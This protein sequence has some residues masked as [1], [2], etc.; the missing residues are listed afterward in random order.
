MFKLFKY[1]KSYII[2]IFITFILVA[3][4]VMVDLSLP[5]YMSKI[6][7]TGIVSN[8]LDYIFKIGLKMLVISLM[9]ALCTIFIS[10]L[11]S[12]I[13]SGFAKTI[14]KEVFSKVEDFSLL[15][16]E[17]FGVSSLITRTTND[18]SQIQLF[19]FMLL[20]VVVAAP[21]MA[22]GGYIKAIEKSSSMAWVIGFSIFSLLIGVIILIII[23]LPKV[24]LLQKYIDKLNL[25]IRE[26]LIG[27]KD[28]KAF[29]NEEY[30]ENKFDTA[31]IDL[32][33]LNLYLNRIMS[34]VNPVIILILNMTVIM[35]I[36]FGAKQIEVGF[37]QVGNLMAFIQYV[38]QIIM[39]F[40]MLS[41]V[42][43]ILP[44]ATVSMQRVAEVINTNP[45]ITDQN[46]PVS[47]NKSRPGL[48]EFKNVSYKYPGAKE[49]VLNNISFKAKPNKVTAFVGSTG[50][51][52]STLINLLLRF[53]D[54]TEGKILIGNT[55]IRCLSQG[56]LRD[57]IGYV[58]QE[59]ILFSG[60]VESNL[61]YGKSNADNDELYE[62]AVR[63]ES[64][65][66]IKKRKRG[67]KSIV[68]QGGTNFSG[69]ER[70]RLSIARAL[71]KSPNIYIFD[72]SF[73]ALDFK[74]D[75]KIRSSFKNNLK[76]STILIIA[77]RINTIMDADQII[78]LDKGEIVGK[79]I[80]QDLLENCPVYKEIALSQ[81]SAEELL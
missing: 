15:E 80:H 35:I 38:M 4:Q 43:S 24:K 12:K 54:V 77:Q 30:Q 76:D 63:S 52:K 62:S 61:K 2:L 68:T 39:S 28:I 16:I 18:I 66:F 3:I 60:T 69:G 58:P 6:V 51:G 8:D 40:L 13:S 20:R 36:W 53:Y 21:I 27:L 5:D 74:T 26:H 33:N 17:K 19:I 50:S 79:G 71:I 57:N 32:S 49:N 10:F 55:D 44:R 46:N 23:G 65:D 14:R 31:N 45:A 75:K 41:M 64:L 47:I 9:G 34:L 1:L 29:N 25:V 70:Q 7:D 22:I 42:L 78:V 59:G 56:E 11:A 81:L 48:V 72:D 37:L 67:F 73:S